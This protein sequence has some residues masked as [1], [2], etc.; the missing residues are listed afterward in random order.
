MVRRLSTRR[1]TASLAFLLL[2]LPAL[3]GCRER[4]RGGEIATA[5]KATAT[6]LAEYY[7]SLVQDTVDTWQLEVFF[8]ATAEGG[9]IPMNE[10][11]AGLMTDRIDE[12]AGRARAARSL[13][14]AY[15]A[16][17]GLTSYDPTGP[18]GTAGKQLAASLGG[19][20][21][22]P[23]SQYAPVFGWVSGEVAALAQSRSIAQ[24]NALMLKIVTDL[25]TMFRAEMEAYGFV[26][27]ERADKAAIVAESLVD[28]KRVDAKPLL[29]P[30]GDL[31]GLKWVSGQPDL[32]DQVLRDAAKGL[33]EVRARQ[34]AL[35]SSR[36]AG[37]MDT[38]LSSL[39]FAHSQLAQGGSPSLDDI[40]VGLQRLDALLSAIE[41]TR[42][43]P[44]E[45]EATP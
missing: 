37:E 9:P 41:E 38:A 25:Q 21:V 44:A 24:A 12:L 2:V 23:G 45:K 33:L 22:L 8:R 6:A 17:Q 36:A 16:M 28:S 11:E 30:I 43:R 29:D 31:V 34:H 26:A 7:D 15:A 4:E 19:I 3:A 32:T 39:I 35:L 42:T 13:A 10:E 40:G 27:Q 1:W 18:A 5:G 20:G 14:D